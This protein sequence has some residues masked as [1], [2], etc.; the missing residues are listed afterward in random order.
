MDKKE[1]FKKFISENEI[2]V[3]DKNPGSRNRLLKIV[4]DLG[5]KRHMVHTA[6]GLVEASG[7]LKEKQISLVL[8][9]YMVAGGSGFDLFKLL[10][11]QQ[12]EKKDLCLVLVTSNISQ[13]AVAKAA[14]EDVDSFII[15]PYTLQSIQENLISTVV[16]KVKPS[17][18][19][20]KIE[21]G[22]EFIH[23]GELD[24]AT[25]CLQEAMKMNSKPALAM[26][27]M[28]QIE[29]MRKYVEEAQGSFQ[30]GLS[31]NTIHFKCL[32]G[33]YDLFLKEKK[34]TEAYQIVKKI[35]KYFPAN[36]DRLTQILRLAVRTENFQDMQFYYDIFISL[37]ERTST[38]TNYMGAGLFVS[39]KYFIKNSDFKNGMQ[40]FDNIAVSCS[41]F[42]KFT[43]ATITFLVE[44]NRTSDAHKY[45]SRFPAGSKNDED[46]LVS[47]YIIASG[48]NT[49]TS[50]LLKKG[51][52]IFNQNIR[53]I[54]CMKILIRAMEQSGLKE[55]RIQEYRTVFTELWPEAEA[56]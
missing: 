13:T 17:D 29:Y 34:F 1:V 30:G 33:L 48:E 35:S 40:C 54:S 44:V 5:A 23:A 3:V 22:K 21:E 38:L 51:F 55:E 37:E 41:E 27:Y 11:E 16:A 28:G 43:R 39:G 12:P 42:T 56:A 10:R 15:K 8:S 47:D 46:Y 50:T 36:P 26:F 32:V 2:L 18:Y 52:E 9:D 7:I 31:F 4:C 53:D 14:E 49:E 25:E 24:A 45:L 6:S 20:L 19:I